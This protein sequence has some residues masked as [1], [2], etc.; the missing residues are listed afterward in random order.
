V[1]M[2]H[3]REGGGYTQKLW[4]TLWIGCH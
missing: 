4:I 3:W 1:P 2:R